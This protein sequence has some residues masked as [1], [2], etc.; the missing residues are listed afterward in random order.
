MA[1]IMSALGQV[2]AA[3]LAAFASIAVDIAE[4]SF[5]AIIEA[6]KGALDDMEENQ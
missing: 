5:V 3:M 1:I 2:G 4:L 6:L